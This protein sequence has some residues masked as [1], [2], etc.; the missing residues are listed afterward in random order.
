MSF[1]N[2]HQDALFQLGGLY[3]IVDSGITLW[4]PVTRKS[5]H[6]M[7]EWFLVLDPNWTDDSIVK[8]GSAL[9]LTTSGVFVIHKSWADAIKRVL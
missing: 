7:V 1:P 4:S 6:S 2:H 3:Q 9:I 5:L 8:Y